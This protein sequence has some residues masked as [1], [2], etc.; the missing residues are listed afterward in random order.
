MAKNY[1]TK[2]KICS[3]VLNM[4]TLEPKFLKLDSL[5]LKKNLGFNFQIKDRKHTK[6]YLYL[7]KY[8]SIK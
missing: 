8:I 1:T 6:K 4:L 2:L 7:I 5:I 3:L